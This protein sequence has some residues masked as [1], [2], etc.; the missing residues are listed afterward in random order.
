[1]KKTLKIIAAFAIGATAGSVL[2]LLLAPEEK[3]TDDIDDIDN[4]EP[5]SRQKAG[6]R[7]EGQAINDND[8]AKAEADELM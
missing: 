4:Q 1:M 8:Y 6:R 2:G 5:R 7:A 3:K